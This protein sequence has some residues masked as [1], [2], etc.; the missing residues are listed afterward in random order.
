MSL[1]TTTH[2]YIP[3]KKSGNN[4]YQLSP[5]PPNSVNLNYDHS[6]ANT[7]LFSRNVKLRRNF[8]GK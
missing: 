8:E 7:P 4:I 1:R 5:Q 3:H 2:Y 6:S